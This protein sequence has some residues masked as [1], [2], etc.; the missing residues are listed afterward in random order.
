MDGLP[1]K[2]NNRNIFVKIFKYTY[3]A[4]EKAKIELMFK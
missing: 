3:F 2:K 4:S 1:E